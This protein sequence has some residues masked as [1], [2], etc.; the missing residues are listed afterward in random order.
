MK[1]RI[2][3]L[4]ACTLIASA[5]FAQ[6]NYGGTMDIYVN[7]AKDYV[8]DEKPVKD[9]G[10]TSA[11]WNFIIWGETENRE[12]TLGF[13]GGLIS[14]NL[15]ASWVSLWWKP[16]EQLFIKIGNIDEDNNWA[17]ADLTGLGLNVN[18][19]HVR[20][21]APTDANAGYKTNSYAGNFLASGTG[22][23]SGN[24]G[25]RGMQLS[26]YPFESL[27][28]NLA[29][30]FDPLNSLETHSIEAIYLDGL[31]AQVVFT[32]G[33]VGEAAISFVNAGLDAKKRMLTKNL[34]AQWKMPLG[35]MMRLELGG[36]FGINEKMDAPL[37]LGL[38]FGYGD[39]E[40]DAL[41]FNTRVG[42]SLPM[43]D[44]DKPIIGLDIMFSYDLEIFRF[45]LPAGVAMHMGEKETL[46][47]WNAAPYI[48]KDLR[49]PSI[50]MGVTLYNG[51]DAYSGFRGA[52]PFQR[53]KEADEKGRFNW[54]IP[55]GVRWVF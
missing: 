10:T 27:A 44:E 38:G 23:M 18:E 7:V 39:F 47:A 51:G 32:P 26:Y 35:E 36:N 50:Y 55:V 34:Y 30:H 13:K 29:F 45:Y 46:L 3:V 24:W 48:A 4:A 2:A 53:F 12:Q 25:T 19:F 42:A 40:E 20:D 49:G 16:I 11:G 8:M 14:E 33:E 22:F 41:V 21:I 37:K 52:T 9:K 5:A 17:G 6:L 54:A 43:I 1:K 28:V 31:N 15:P